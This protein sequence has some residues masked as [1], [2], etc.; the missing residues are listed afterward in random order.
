MSC[1]ICRR[2]FRK[3][4]HFNKVRFCRYIYIKV[5]SFTIFLFLSHFNLQFFLSKYSRMIAKWVVPTKMFMSPVPSYPI[6]LFTP[7]SY[8]RSFA[9]NCSCVNDTCHCDYGFTGNGTQCSRKLLSRKV[10]K[11][12]KLMKYEVSKLVPYVIAFNAKIEI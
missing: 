10:N 6:H 9:F 11:F 12:W 2:T 8:I 4:F 7:S 5:L 3:P 1:S